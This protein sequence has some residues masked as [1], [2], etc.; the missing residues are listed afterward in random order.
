MQFNTS[1]VV[2]CNLCLY[3]SRVTGKREVER[4]EDYHHPLTLEERLQE[5]MAAREWLRENSVKWGYPAT[6]EC[7]YMNYQI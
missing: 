2:P 4:R 1:D 7:K 5:V 3:I 6:P